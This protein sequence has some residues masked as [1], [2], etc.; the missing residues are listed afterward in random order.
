MIELSRWISR[1]QQYSPKHPLSAQLAARTHE[2]VIRALREWTP[3]EVGVLRDKLTIGQTPAR[4]PA[5]V[6]RLAPYLH[7]RGVLVLRIA[8]GVS[9]AELTSLVEVLAAPPAEIFSAG[10][11]RALLTDRHVA[12][13][14]VDEIAHELTIEDR[15]RIR[16]EQHLREL[17][18]EMLMRLLSNGQVPPDIGA[19]IAELAEHPD[20]AVRV[21]QS[22]PH[23]NLAEAVAAFSLILMQEEQRCGEALLEKMG[24]ILLHLAPESRVRVLLGYPPL[25]GDF[26]QALAATFDVLGEAQLA[27]FVFPCVRAHAADLDATLY[28]LGVAATSEER[29]AE[30]ARRLAG[31]LYD[32]NL[33]EQPSQ[34]LLRTLAAETPEAGSFASERAVLGDAAR[35]ILQTRG[36][37][38]RHGED[39]LVDSRAFARAELD[40]LAQR[41]ALDVVARSARMVDFDRFCAQLP[42]TARTLTTEERAPAV[43]GLLL[44]LAAV[45][46]PRW[47][48]LAAKTLAQI[49]RSGV[50]ALA[51]RATEQLAGRG[52]DAQMDDVLLLAR[53]MVAHNAEPVL[54]LLERSDSRK[55]RRALIDV[56]LS[57]GGGLLPSVQTRLQSSQWYVTRNMIILHTRLG[58]GAEELR[59]LADHPHAQVRVEVVRSL[60]AMARDPVASDIVVGRLSD[61]APEVAQAAI[62]SLATMELSGPVVSALAALAADEARSEDARRTAIQVLGGSRS[63]AAPDALF[64]LMQPH[65]LI[66][67]PSTATLREDAA[68][69][70]HGCPATCARDRFEEAQHSTVRRVRKACERALGRDHQDG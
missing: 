13:V 62:S 42:A 54:D 57:A 6:T 45:T 10:G 19:H 14:Q 48:E 28:A 58:G 17:F 52:D 51:L 68:R 63:D 30:V 23:V 26:R 60:R 41:A 25:V 22:E 3:L 43:A 29:R 32:L 69:A 5:L 67:G 46:E 40:G 36:P 55:L 66:E 61:R 31:L 47:A 21:I 53:V 35:R 12:H 44:G 1:A 9:S 20:L 16:K 7:E 18:R 8:D 39:E 37:L 64:R 2:I 27:R 33:D 24:P 11:L 38:H 34:D 15:E 49:A 65:G 4:H 70:L 50:S 56:L 59:A